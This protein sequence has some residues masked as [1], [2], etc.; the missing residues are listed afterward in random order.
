MLCSLSMSGSALCLFL[1][2]LEATLEAMFALLIAGTIH[3][4]FKM[5]FLAIGVSAA[6]TNPRNHAAAAETVGAQ[7]ALSEAALVLGERHTAVWAGLVGFE[8]ALGGLLVTG[9]A[10]RETV[11]IVGARLVFVLRFVA[12]GAGL[13]AAV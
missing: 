2:L 8:S 7:R 4:A 12:V 11:F 9:V 1:E 13:V 3:A 5:G 10:G 6:I